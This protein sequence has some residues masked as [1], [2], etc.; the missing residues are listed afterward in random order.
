[1][2][3]ISAAIPPG[4]DPST[5]DLQ[6]LVSSSQ[7]AKYSSDGKVVRFYVDRLKEGETKA[8]EYHLRARYPVKAMAPASSAYLYYQPEVRAESKAT[9]LVV[10]QRD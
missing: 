1:M 3:L 7:V 10:V 5:E 8:F 4:F 2:V 9:P 6:A